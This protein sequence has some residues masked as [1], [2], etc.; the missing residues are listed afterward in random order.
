MHAHE[1]SSIV[2]KPK[3]EKD[4]LYAACEATTDVI[5]LARLLSEITTLSKVPVLKFDN[6]STIKLVKNPVSQLHE[7]H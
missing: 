7:T 4:E 6:M 3:T 2:G 1:W 5:W